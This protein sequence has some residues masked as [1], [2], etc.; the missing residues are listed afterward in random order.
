MKS[1]PVHGAIKEGLKSIPAAALQKVLMPKLK[2]AGVR[3]YKVVARDLAEHLLSNPDKE[4]SWGSGRDPKRMNITFGEDDVAEV[5]KIAKRIIDGVPDL[6]DRISRETARDMIARF[7][8]EWREARYRDLRAL[9][10]FH[11]NLED[12]WG[13][14]LDALRMLLDLSR[15]LGAQCHDQLATSKRQKGKLVRA[16]VV[17]LHVRSCQISAEILVLLENGFPDGALARWRTLHE[18][19]IVA[20]L[21]NTGGDE[22]AVKYSDHEI[23]EAKKALDRFMID[24]E[25]LG[26]RKPSQ[27]DLNATKRSYDRVI[28]KY[29][30]SFRHEYGWA[31]G[32]L[33]MERPRFIDLQ[34][35]AG[36]AAMHSHYKF[37]SYNVHATARALSLRV[38]AIDYNDPLISGATNAGLDEAGM[39]VAVSLALITSFLIPFGRSRL[40]NVVNMLAILD[41]RDR[42]IQSLGHSQKQLSKEDREIKLAMRE[43]ELVY[44]D[45]ASII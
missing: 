10:S 36:H 34:N 11:N 29:G 25:A 20:T 23:V 12:R 17:R 8:I 33:K 18:V 41:L 27:R 31:A 19:S 3:T 9:S 30:P 1:N 15:Q 42:A 5:E 2:D 39:K 24:H 13:E 43:Y 38:G 16:A 14:G 40:D 44:D 6:V 7:A 45:S 4:F 26:F 21:L 28:A 32:M 35:A 22:L 37:A